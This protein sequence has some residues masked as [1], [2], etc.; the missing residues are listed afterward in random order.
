M[1]PLA[2]SNTCVP[3]AYLHSLLNG[4]YLEVLD[5]LESVIEESI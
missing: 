4:R 1:V 5:L 2:V 3:I